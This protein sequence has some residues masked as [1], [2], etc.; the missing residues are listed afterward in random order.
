MAIAMTVWDG[1]QW[2][3]ALSLD[4]E[5]GHGVEVTPD[6]FFSGNPRFS[7]SL[8]WQELLKR[9]ELSS[10]MIMG[11]AMCRSYVGQSRKLSPQAVK[12]LRAVVRT[13]AEEACSL[14]SDEADMLYAKIY[15]YLDRLFV[16]SR[17]HQL[18]NS[19]SRRLQ[20]ERRLTAAD[21]LDELAPLTRL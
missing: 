4:S 11:N 8:A 9:L 19:L 18:A 20:D 6:F 3:A 10:A 16:H 2:L 15:D 1:E 17:V 14:E 7:A 12:A 21:V 13:E 5:P